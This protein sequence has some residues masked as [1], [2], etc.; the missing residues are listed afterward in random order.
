MD[1]KAKVE[2]ALHALATCARMEA[3]TK[4]LREE[5]IAALA[6]EG[7]TPLPGKRFE[8]QN[9]VVLGTVANVPSLVEVPRVMLATA[10]GDGIVA[11]VWK[12]LDAA[13]PGAVTYTEGTGPLRFRPDRNA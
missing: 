4:G 11:P 2:A 12:V 6:E 3:V 13:H 1:A 10:I 5:A 9:G 7:L 8:V